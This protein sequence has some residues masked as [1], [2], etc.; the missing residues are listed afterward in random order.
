MKTADP[1]Q[2]F[3]DRVESYVRARPGYPPEVLATLRLDCGL[4]PA[5]RIADVASGTGIFTRLLLENG[6]PVFAVEPNHEMRSAAEQLLAS[7]PNFTSVAGS[8]EATTLPDHSVAIVTAAQ[9]AHWFNLPRARAEFTR[10]LN[11]GGWV[12]LLWNER[13]TSTT[14]FLR[15]YEQ[16]LLTFAIDYKEVRHE[17]TT[18][19]IGDFFAPL[20]HRERV[21]STFQDLDYS[22]LELRLL[23]SSYAPLADHPNHAPMLR[24]LQRIFDAGQRNGQVRLDYQTRL[25][26]AQFP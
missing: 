18:A 9:A 7:F 21:Y 15:E 2:R 13:V 26:Y 1:T 23:S 4:T 17:K 24:E 19:V 12:A 16:L 3:S 5:T 8:A 25:Y 11:P 6:N 20:P 10:I 22:A 14:P